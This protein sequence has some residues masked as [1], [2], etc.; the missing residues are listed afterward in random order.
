MDELFSGKEPVEPTYYANKGSA[1]TEEALT[2]TAQPESKYLLKVTNK[3]ST[4]YFYPFD[5]FFNSSLF[6]E[7]CLAEASV[8]P[9]TLSVQGKALPEDEDGISFNLYFGEEETVD[10]VIAEEPAAEEFDYTQMIVDGALPYQI[11]GQGEGYLQS[12]E[13]ED[14]FKVTPEVTGIYELKFPNMKK[15]EFPLMEVYQLVEGSTA[16]SMFGAFNEEKEKP[17]G[18]EEP[19]EKV[20]EPVDSEEPGE[21]VEEPG[22]SEKPG[23]DG[24]ESVDSEEPSEE[25]E[26]NGPFLEYDWFK[27]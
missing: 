15:N 10:D 4:F 20:E 22:D 24:E 25:E 3:P 7:S 26:D 5:F 11:G 18:T 12:L 2:F 8:I 14:W 1:S 21:E 6:D 16:Y 17:V 9:Y 23:K 27:L 19:V 13:D